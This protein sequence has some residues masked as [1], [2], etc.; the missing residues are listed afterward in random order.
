M[1][2]TDEIYSHGY[3]GPSGQRFKA[4]LAA[5]AIQ[6]AL[7]FGLISGLAFDAVETVTTRIGAFD[8]PLP[9]PPPPQPEPTAKAEAPPR[10]E[11]KASPANLE[12]KA[13]PRV[14]PKPEIPI[15]VRQIDAAKVEGTGRDA[16]AGASTVA[17]AGTGAGGIGTGT[18]TGG[19]GSGMGGGGGGPAR[20]VA[21]G[22]RDSD[23]PQSA[24]RER[25]SGTVFVQFTVQPNGRVTGCTVTRSS[26]S[27]LLDQTTCRVV[28]G[29]FRYRP[30]TNAA[31][32]PIAEV[33]STNFTFGINQ[34]R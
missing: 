30:A 18:G 13:K 29:R 2:A 9:P 16:D 34:R 33:V 32:E 3:G 27:P 4:I 1:A 20:R 15:P 8:V 17:G 7:I 21:G 11:G 5:G 12:A 31:G 14:A 24:L 25:V 6:G 10:E 19:A 28:E 22:I 23:Y 26:G